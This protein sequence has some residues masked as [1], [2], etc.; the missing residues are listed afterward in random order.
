MG[1]CINKYNLCQGNLELKS[2][3]FKKNSG[4]FPNDDLCNNKYKIDENIMKKIIKI[5]ISYKNHSSK[6]CIT[7][8][9]SINKKVSSCYKDSIEKE[10][11]SFK[12]KFNNQSL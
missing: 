3:N 10:N 11:F 7:K 6:K 4:F 12:R 9:R 8:E 1:T 2:I 5:Q